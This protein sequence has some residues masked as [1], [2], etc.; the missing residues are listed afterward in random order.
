MRGFLFLL[1]VAAIGVGALW[2]GQYGVGPVIV[3][4]ENEFNI[5]LLL[6]T[7]RKT[8]DQPGI[9]WRLPILE[10]TQTLDKRLQYLNAQPVE[11]LIGNET[12][13]VDYYAVW[14]IEDPL[15]FSRSYPGGKAEAST[16]IQRR[17]KSLVGD[18]IGKLP[19]QQVLSRA[20]VFDE[21]DSEASAALLEKGVVVLDLRINRTEIPRE[22]ESAAFEQMREQ[23]RAIS[24]EHR[25]RGE[26]E[27]REMRARAEREART[28]VAGAR[29][30]AEVTRGDGDAQAAAIYAAA[31]SG[32]PEFY[33]FVR[34][35]EAYRKGLEE[36][37][38]MVLAPDHEFFRYLQPRGLRAR[39]S[40]GP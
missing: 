36:R 20:A 27:A 32:D 23:R 26:R 10:S 31:Y 30:Q 25:A 3:T 21:L 8:I 38:T 13:S 35:L 6:G 5:V 17:L 15:A 16:A 22:A 37:T 1:V 19:L 28:T 33:A 34:S 12:L 11:L 18:K 29:S 4:K 2:A 40:P 7:P 9:D 14:R 39:P 24:R